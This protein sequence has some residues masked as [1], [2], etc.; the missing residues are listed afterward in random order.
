MAKQSIY[1]SIILAY[2][3][4]N[5]AQ[6]CKEMLDMLQMWPI[7]LIETKGM[8]NQWGVDCLGKVNILFVLPTFLHSQQFC[9][10]NIF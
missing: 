7:R 3:C 1:P 4:I 10:P 5:N 2:K 8:G 6:D 9:P